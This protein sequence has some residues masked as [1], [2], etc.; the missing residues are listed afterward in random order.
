MN[1]LKQY[2]F[3]QFHGR[4]FLLIIALYSGFPGFSQFSNS[5]IEN[6]DTILALEILEQTDSLLDLRQIPLAF[7]R[8]EKARIVFEKAQSWE[9][10]VETLVYI[11]TCHIYQEHFEKSFLYLDT[12]ALLANQHLSQDAAVYWDIYFRKGDL[13]LQIDEI[14]S[15]KVYLSKAAEIARSA[16]KWEDYT[17]T[18]ISLSIVYYYLNDFL[19]METSLDNAL[20][21]ARAHLS[22]EHEVFEVAYSNQAA[23]Y[24]ETGEFDKSFAVGK[25]ALEFRLRLGLESYQDSLDLA[26]NYQN[27]GAFYSAKGEKELALKQY[28]LALDFYEKL[29]ADLLTIANLYLN[30]G[31]SYWLLEKNKTALSYFRKMLFTLDQKKELPL[32]KQ[33]AMAYIR[34]YNNIGRMLVELEEFDSARYYLNLALP[35]SLK[36][37]RNLDIT[38][39]GFGLL[40]KGL[41]GKRQCHSFF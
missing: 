1:R 40:K 4:L 38:Y 7:K 30:I 13:F 17:W 10:Y 18:E 25:K 32:K 16:K 21:A 36:F 11:S 3:G 26:I 27:I 35:L 9:K 22:L 20:T 12:A 23:L 8:L 15:S 34:A 31:S 37:R 2:S 39:A 14:D 41:Q 29:N 6:A 24:D 5:V 19:A 28:F 33:K